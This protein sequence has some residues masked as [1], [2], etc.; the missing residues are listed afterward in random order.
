MPMENTGNMFLMLLG[1]Y[2][3]TKDASFFYPHFFPLLR[4][5]ANYL[6][7]SLPFP[8]YQVG[9]EPGRNAPRRGAVATDGRLTGTSCAR[10]ISLDGWPTTPTSLPKAS[11]RCRRLLS[12]A[13]PSAKTALTW[14]RGQLTL[15]RQANPRPR[16]PPLS[17]AFR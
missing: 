9:Q 16:P 1:I 17:R 15:P 5:W 7:A 14:R 3:Q 10:M 8:A 6:N 4:S 12:S 13:Q 2:R 11:W